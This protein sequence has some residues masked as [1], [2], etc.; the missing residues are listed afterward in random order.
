[1]LMFT[2]LVEFMKEIRLVRSGDEDLVRLLQLEYKK[3]WE[4]VYLNYLT[5]GKIQNGF[6]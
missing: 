2:G 5:T 6:N 3:D 4:S 1:M